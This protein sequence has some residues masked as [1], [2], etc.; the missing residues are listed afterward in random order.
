MN[1]TIVKSTDTLALAKSLVRID[2]EVTSLAY[3]LNKV[4][5]KASDYG[6]IA[7]AELNLFSGRKITVTALP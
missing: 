3:E 7:C 1:L 2:E 4:R 5:R 6:I